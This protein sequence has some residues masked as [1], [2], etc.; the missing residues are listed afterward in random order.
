MRAGQGRDTVRGALPDDPGS[1]WRARSSDISSRADQETNLPGARHKWTG[2]VGWRGGALRLQAIR[3]LHQ[4]NSNA[5]RHR[6]DAETDMG[7]SK[8]EGRWESQATEKGEDNQKR[9]KRN[10]V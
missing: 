9:E 4:T 5:I 10:K 2:G 3:G 8:R 6:R 7:W 1:R